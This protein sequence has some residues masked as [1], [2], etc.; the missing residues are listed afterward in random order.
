LRFDVAADGVRYGWGQ[1]IATLP[2]GVT[3]TADREALK[4]YA[5]GTASGGTLK[6]AGRGR[7]LAVAVDPITG[8]VR[9]AGGG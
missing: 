4:F 7:A 1:T 3:A 2:F 9:P 5:D 8:V 6:L